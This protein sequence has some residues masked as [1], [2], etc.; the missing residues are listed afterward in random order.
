MSLYLWLLWREYVKKI[1]ETEDL[2]GT[3]VGTLP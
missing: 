3:E 2:P 1:M